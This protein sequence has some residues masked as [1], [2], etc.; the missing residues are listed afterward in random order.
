M[1]TYIVEHFLHRR[2]LKALLWPN[3]L[4]NPLK[5]FNVWKFS[6]LNNGTSSHE[7]VMGYYY[8]RQIMHSHDKTDRHRHPGGYVISLFMLHIHRVITCL[9]E[10]VIMI[11]NRAR[12][13]LNNSLNPLTLTS[14]RSSIVWAMNEIELIKALWQTTTQTGD[15][16]LPLSHNHW[17]SDICWKWKIF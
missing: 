15:L 16:W 3:Y 17:S 5:Y 6:L 9:F 14:Q 12:F 8:A 13:S 10:N 7:N 2:T 11:I 4:T 1:F